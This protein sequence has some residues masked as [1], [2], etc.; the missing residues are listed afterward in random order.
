LL[1]SRLQENVE[2]N[3]VANLRLIAEAVSDRSGSISFYETRFGNCGVGHVFE[4]GHRHN[5]SPSYTVPTNT[6]DFYV[7]SLRMPSLI[8]VDIEGAEWL[9]LNG[10]SE[11]LE[12]SDAPDFLIEFHPEEIQALSS[13]TFVI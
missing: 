12:R 10:A 9:A 1:V 5:A 4:F 3:E 7:S 8:K 6:L 13:I 2:L 11:T